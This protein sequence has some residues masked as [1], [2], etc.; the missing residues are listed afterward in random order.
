[1]PGKP[2]PGICTLGRPCTGPRTCACAGVALTMANAMASN[3]TSMANGRRKGM[4][5]GLG[6]NGAGC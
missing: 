4:A 1:M 3:E 2:T 5:N 6:S